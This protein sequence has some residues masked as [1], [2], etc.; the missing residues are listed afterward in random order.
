MRVESLNPCL[1]I[2]L[3]ALTMAST[4]RGKRC[5]RERFWQLGI[6]GG[7][8]EGDIIINLPINDI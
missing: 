5:S 2:F 8:A 7:G 3:A 6:L 4:S 1:P